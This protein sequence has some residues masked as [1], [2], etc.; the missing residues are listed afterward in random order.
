MIGGLATAGY[1]VAGGVFGLIA[2]GVGLV[3]AFDARRDTWDEELHE[4]RRTYLPAFCDGLDQANHRWHRYDYRGP[5]RAKLEVVGNEIGSK[6]YQPVVNAG[7]FADRCLLGPDAYKS[8]EGAR[9]G[10]VDICDKWGKRSRFL[11]FGAF[12]DEQ[13]KEYG[14]QLVMLGCIERAKARA[15][16]KP[17]RLP[18]TG[19]GMILLRYQQRSILSKEPT[20]SSAQASPQ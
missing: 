4:F 16:L 5:S 7:M 20:D 13:W 12:L 19:L 11:G 17:D 1:P 10:L 8:F 6:F 9:A 3:F 14:Q 15:L 2:I 18:E